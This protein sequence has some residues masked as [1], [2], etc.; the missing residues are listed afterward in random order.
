MPVCMSAVSA[1]ISEVLIKYRGNVWLQK[2]INVSTL[3]APHDV[4]NVIKTRPRL[5]GLGRN[6]SC[7]AGVSIL[8][9]HGSMKKFN[10]LAKK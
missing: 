3:S 2:R 5:R 8:F 4:T 1:G 9:F 6:S 10:Q 7:L